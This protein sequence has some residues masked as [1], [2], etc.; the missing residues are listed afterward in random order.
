M[1]G[2]QSPK[3]QRT[4]P[5]HIET[6]RLI[7]IIIIIIIIQMDIVLWYKFTQNN[8]LNKELL[9]TGDAE[10]VEVREYLRIS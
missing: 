6:L 8:H 3:G 2:C 4:T 7:T 9:E 10:L 5:S 1:A